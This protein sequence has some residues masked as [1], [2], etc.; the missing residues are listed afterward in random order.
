MAF[1][2][3][4]PMSL[5][6]TIP[7]DS[8]LFSFVGPDSYIR[9]VLRT[10]PGKTLDLQVTNDGGVVSAV[11]RPDTGGAEECRG[12]VAVVTAG[13]GGGRLFASRGVKLH[14]SCLHLSTVLSCR[15][16]VLV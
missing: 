1:S 3:I 12:G 15:S 11:F 9:L 6:S 10:S 4:P 8:R 13:D 14:C 7:V 5:S 2:A 16:V